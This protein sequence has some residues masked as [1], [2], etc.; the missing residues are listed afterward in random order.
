MKLK[1]E[2]YYWRK[3]SQRVAMFDKRE[4]KDKNHCERS[5]LRRI[6]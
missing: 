6:A 4:L 1:R 2:Y 5:S 3:Q